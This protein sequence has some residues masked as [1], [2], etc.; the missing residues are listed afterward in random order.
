MFPSLSE[1]VSAQPVLHGSTGLG[2]HVPLAFMRIPGSGPA[3]ASQNNDTPTSKLHGWF[4][5]LSLQGY[6][7]LIFFCPNIKFKTHLSKEGSNSNRFFFSHLFSKFN[8]LV[9]LI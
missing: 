1:G 5:A 7:F 8:S 3:E 9:L 4:N 2:F 6:N